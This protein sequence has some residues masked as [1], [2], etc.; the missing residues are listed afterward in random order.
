[1]ASEPCPPPAPL[2]RDVDVA[3]AAD[4]VNLA[5]Q[6]RYVR[7]IAV[8]LAEREVRAHFAVQ[9]VHDLLGCLAL[10]PACKHSDSE[11]VRLK[12]CFTISLARMTL[13]KGSGS[14]GRE[15]QSYSC[16]QDGAGGSSRGTLP[17]QGSHGGYRVCGSSSNLHQG[18]S[19]LHNG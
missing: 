5:W 10:V 17:E 7:N 14:V 11:C 4:A 16:G 13:R 2:V 19:T 12:A 8:D 9:Q 18:R 1:M 6:K 15:W 3:D